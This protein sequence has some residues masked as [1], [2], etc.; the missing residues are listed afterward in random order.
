[1]ECDPVSGVPPARMVSVSRQGL[2]GTWCSPLAPS[3]RPSVEHNYVL[4][5]LFFIGL[6][7]EVSQSHR[8]RSCRDQSTQFTH[9]CPVME[10]AAGPVRVTCGGQG[11]LLSSVSPSGVWSRWRSSVRWPWGGA[12]GS[13]IAQVTSTPCACKAIRAR[14]VWLLS[15]T[16]WKKCKRRLWVAMS[17]F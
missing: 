1:M 16:A 14:P 17:A 7:R 6:S 10:A 9:F 3:L 15:R 5:H 2:L 12:A 4:V 13:G 8:G 11:G